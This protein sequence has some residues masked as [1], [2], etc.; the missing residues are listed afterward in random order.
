MEKGISAAHAALNKIALFHLKRDY[1]GEDTTM[2]TLITPTDKVF[3]FSL[4]DRIRDV[5]VKGKTCIPATKGN[6]YYHLGIR[7]SP[8][9]GEVVVIYTHKEKDVY[10]L[11]YDGMRFEFIL[12]HG[13]NSHKDTEGCVLLAKNRGNDA[14]HGSLKKEITAEIK[15]LISQGYDCRLKVSNP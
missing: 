15:S 1:A 9:Y 7:I 4:E 2:G 6:D 3:G 8:K 12:I 13:G 11:E 10:V 14:I 5:K